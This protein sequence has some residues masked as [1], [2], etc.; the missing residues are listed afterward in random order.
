MRVH[1]LASAIAL[2]AALGLGLIAAL[3]P[4][5][6]RAQET[7]TINCAYPFW[8]GFGPVHLASELGY[9]EEEGLRVTEVFD[10]DRGNVLPALERGDI[11]CTMRT[12]GEY[13]G[14]PRTPETQGRIV[15]TIDI[16]MGG[17]GVLV[18]GEIDSICDLKGKTFAAEPNTPA[19]LLAQV[20]LKEQCDLTFD[21][22]TAKDIASADAIGVFAD[23]SIAGV[24]VYEPVLTQALKASN[25]EG[26]RIILSSKDYP[27]LITDVIII[28]TDELEANPE[29]YRKFL[30]GIYRAVDYYKEN[31]EK[32]VAIMAPNFQLSEAD[33]TETL[34][35]VAY[36]DY[37]EATKL[38]GQG[39][40]PGELHGIFDRV[41]Q[42]NLEAG[43]ADTELKPAEQIDNGPI[44]DL[45]SDAKG[46]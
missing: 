23:D 40:Q 10:D 26:S 28:R 18:S 5:D 29:K 35:N 45:F 39:D 2:P 41:M 6:A 34:L 38:M 33:L 44:T 32:A 7:E 9:F 21:D 14:R 11:D 1:T 46:G 15:G 4:A 37:A 42:M 13:Q 12:V 3:A 20:A 19:R 27:Y 17:D 31:P 30:R 43:T 25:R 24:A 22:L 36:T 16:S 8:P